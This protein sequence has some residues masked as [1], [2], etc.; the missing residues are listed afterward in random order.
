MLDL[1]AGIHF[2][3]IEVALAIQHEFHGAGTAIIDTGGSLDG[4]F[5]HCLAQF[6][7]H[8]RAGGLLDDL[9]MAPL[10]RTIALAEMDQVAETV[11]EYLDLHVTGANQGFFEDQLSTAEGAPG[12]GAG[13]VQLLGQLVSG[14]HQAHAA[15]AAAGAGLDHQRKTDG[16]RFTHQGGI[17][18]GIGLISG[19]TGDPCLQHGQLGQT[20]AAHQSDSPRGG[21]DEE[22]P[23]LGA[24][25][26]KI[27]IFRQKAVAWMNRVGAAAFCRVN[28]GRDVQVG[29]AG[30]GRADGDGLVSQLHMKAV[31]VCR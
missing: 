29:L 16:L 4:G 30:G 3:K 14:L 9:L 15:T 8:H 22:Q 23:G 18:L 25:L 1:E 21:A 24:G 13:A 2:Q 31:G 17:V 10:Y 28:D 11:A 7:C 27:R 19:D 20:L 26:G 12:F 6:G 5:A